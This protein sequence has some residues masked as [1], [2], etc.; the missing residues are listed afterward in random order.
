MIQISLCL[1]VDFMIVS[2]KFE[3]IF[4]IL[5]EEYCPEEEVVHI[6]SN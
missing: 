2:S 6:G 5:G 3:R 1:K 4:K